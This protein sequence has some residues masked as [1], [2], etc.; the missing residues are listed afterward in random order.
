MTIAVSDQS[1]IPGQFTRIAVDRATSDARL[2]STRPAYIQNHSYNQFNAPSQQCAE[3]RGGTYTS[4]SRDFD[5]AVI[6]ADSAVSGLQPI[7]LTVS[8]GNID[9][10]NYPADLT[11]ADYRRLAQ[12]PATAKNVIAVGMAETM[13]TDSA[14][15]NCSGCLSTSFNNAASNSAHGTRVAGRF[16]PDLLAVAANVA[17]ARSDDTVKTADDYCNNGGAQQTGQPDAS[18]TPSLPTGYWG[19]TG[20]S[21]AAPVAAGAAVLASSVFAARQP[22]GGPASASPALLKAMLVVGAKSMKGGRDRSELTSWRPVMRYL[23]G[24]RVIPRTP[25]GRIYRASATSC[26]TI[27]EP[28]WSGTTVTETG[29]LGSGCSGNPKAVWIDD[30]PDDAGNLTLGASPSLTQGF[31]RISLE[32]VVSRY[33]SRDL[34][35]GAGISHGNSWTRT[36]RVHDSGEPVKVALAWTDVPGQV[37]DGGSIATSPLIND[38]DLVVEVGS[39]CATKYVGNYIDASTDRSA[40]VACSAPSFPYDAINNVE[41]VRLALPAGTLFTVRIQRTNGG[42]DATQ[43]FGL[44]VFNA[45]EG[46][47]PPIGVPSGL[48]AT[49]DGTNRVNLAWNP[50]SGAGVTYTIQRSSGVTSA[51][52]DRISGL[53]ATN[54]TDQ[55]V[56]EGTSYLY[57]VLATNSSPTVGISNVD[58]ATLVAF[59]ADAFVT[60]VVIKAAHINQLRSAIGAVRSCAGLSTYAWSSHP[61]VA[62]TP[63]LA[64][65]LNE[66]RAASASARSA[67]GLPAI[68]YSDPSI[69]P[70]QTIVRSVHFTEL[71][72]GLK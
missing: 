44:V 32:D 8:A 62:G 68:V 13:R 48:V 43:D 66:L 28:L 56:I 2:H 57:R 72:D 54:W 24:D 59:D 12:P 50:A 67:L 52:V 40:N 9:Q 31:G 46:T 39:P 60:G 61:L 19:S 14:A 5:R 45:Y 7:T 18:P 30:G 29:A 69:V 55:N 4:L 63:I 27:E 70:M 15:W 35:N 1:E 47:D 6:D 10:Q 33:P 23:T 65:H 20:T 71:R 34:V 26:S 3:Y 51:F 38:L 22:S 21:F 25:N 37:E 53:T 64:T 36:Y 42:S 16:K 17:V 49:A 41:V 58:V 11:C